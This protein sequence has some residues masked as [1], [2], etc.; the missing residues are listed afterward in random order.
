MRPETRAPP[1]GRSLA[2]FPASPG[3]AIS[4]ISD[5]R[6]R[7]PASCD[8]PPGSTS[9]PPSAVPVHR[10][11]PHSK[12]IV[13]S[14]VARYGPDA[15]DSALSVG[16]LISRAST[17]GESGNSTRPASRDAGTLTMPFAACFNDAFCVRSRSTGRS[18][19]RC[20]GPWVK[21]FTG[22]SSFASP[23]EVTI[24]EMLTLTSEAFEWLSP[25]RQ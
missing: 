17:H 6:D 15:V 21:D 23:R 24:A 1:R 5:A 22:S 8:V 3:A 2:P 4:P 7:P 12:G 20:R 9:S 11:Q 10:S 19:P 18:Y 25:F 16:I 13:L 14:R